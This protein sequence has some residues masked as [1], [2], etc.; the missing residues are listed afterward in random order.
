MAAARSRR[1]RGKARNDSGP[2]GTPFE[3]RGE[4]GCKQRARRSGADQ[5]FDFRPTERMSTLDSAVA[6]E[7]SAGLPFDVVRMRVESSTK[8]WL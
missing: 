3:G 1:R 4:A 5:N 7:I 2:A 6:V 8:M